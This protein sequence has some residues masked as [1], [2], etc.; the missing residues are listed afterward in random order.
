M[1]SDDEIIE[2]GE[3]PIEITDAVA[4]AI[5]TYNL[6]VTAVTSAHTGIAQSY[7]R[8]KPYRLFAECFPEN[9]KLLY[10]ILKKIF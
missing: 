10:L 3:Y 8:V 5:N 2:D 1:P 6:R 7:I 4:H 9:K